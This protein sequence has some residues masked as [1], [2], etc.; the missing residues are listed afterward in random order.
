MQIFVALSA[1]HPLDGV[2]A[3]RPAAAIQA[4][5]DGHP[6]LG[7]ARSE[8][9]WSPSRHTLVVSLGHPA[10]RA[11]GLART[12]GSSERRQVL[13]GFPIVRGRTLPADGPIDLYGDGRPDGRFG[14]LDVDGD[15]VAVSCSCIG[16]YA[17]YARRLPGGV[18]AVGNSAAL[19]ARIP[20]HP[21]F[22]D[23][24]L[25]DYL[26]AG[27]VFGDR[28]VWDGIQRLP[29]G[30]STV[31]DGRLAPSPARLIDPALDAAARPVHR[32]LDVG[33]DLLK[34]SLEAIAAH[35]RGPIDLGLSGG[36]D[37]RV[38]LAAAV[39]AGVTP[40]LY[41]IAIQE[42]P[43]YPET[44]DVVAARRIAA[45][46][47]LELEVRTVDTT[48]DQ[49]ER[50]LR[51]LVGG[52]SAVDAT[53][54]CVDVGRPTSVLLSGAA[55]ELGW[56]TYGRELEQA[57][58]DDAIGAAIGSW[59]HGFPAHL[60]TDGARERVLA[61]GFAG[62]RAWHDAGL[63]STML[64]ESV[65]AFERAAGWGAPTHFAYEPFFDTVA[66]GWSAELLPLLWSLDPR[67]RDKDRWRRQMIH[68]LCPEIEELPF[69]GGSPVWPDEVKREAYMEWGERRDKIR[70]FVRSRVTGSGVGRVPA[71]VA[72][73]QAMQRE[74]RDA[75]DELD[76]L[77]RLVNVRRVRRL[78]GASIV[79]MDPRSLQRLV[80]LTHVVR[81]L[82][83]AG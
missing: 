18:V 65:F 77:R 58:P 17:V 21:G 32:D 11:G 76:P 72:A 36:R 13:D 46:L 29:P 8:T 20:P 60:G 25:E 83:E 63:P 54:S 50:W 59:I 2:T 57:S 31:A 24:A 34:Q 33:A 79:R 75:L 61:R 16:S 4:I 5:A 45:E 48:L 47:G 30:T 67:D 26:L 44:G 39:A 27:W 69:S 66:P 56:L 37:S 64:A 68:L 43:A 51:T 53:P 55:V 52:V 62:P 3:E 15:R 1:D 41:T 74:V 80:R 49:S 7:G 81:L 38:I 6:G 14:F 40:H 70:R 22:D 42:D 23:E 35:R 19:L 12:W 78:C 82:R 28:T 71:Q 73:L 10:V 9:W